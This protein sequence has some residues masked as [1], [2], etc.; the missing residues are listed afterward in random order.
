M[1][2]VN[3]L[4]QPQSFAQ[5]HSDLNPILERYGIKPAAP[6][7]GSPQRP[8]PGRRLVGRGNSSRPKEFDC[9]PTNIHTPVS[10]RIGRI[11]GLAGSCLC[12]HTR[13]YDRI[14]RRS[15]LR[16]RGFRNPNWSSTRTQ[17]AQTGVRGR[18]P[19][20]ANYCAQCDET[21]V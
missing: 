7:Q 6:G 18:L 9:Q 2:L 15:R 3:S 20:K 10:F 8:L 14:M 13:Y 17:E 1:A 19:R 16:S 4:S 12:G 11:I 5:V 21:E